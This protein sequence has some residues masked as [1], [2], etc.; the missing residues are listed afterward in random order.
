[1]YAGYPLA[2]VVIYLEIPSVDIAVGQVKEIERIVRCYKDYFI[3]NHTEI[4]LAANLSRNNV[5]QEIR[6]LPLKNTCI[7]KVLCCS[8]YPAPQLL[9][10]V[11]TKE[12]GKICHLIEDKRQQVKVMPVS[13]LGLQYENPQENVGN[14]Q[15]FITGSMLP[16][17]GRNI[18]VKCGNIWQMEPLLKDFLDSISDSLAELVSQKEE[19]YMLPKQQ[20]FRLDEQ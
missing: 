14:S 13:L 18:M 19:L 16:E 9:K 5:K 20:T 2:P 17:F 11:I 12:L 10:S 7:S 15:N 6:E 1:M 8:G 3:K 4:I